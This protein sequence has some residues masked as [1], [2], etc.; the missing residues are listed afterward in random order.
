MN[1]ANYS[2]SPS[3]IAL[4]DNHKLDLIVFEICFKRSLAFYETGHPY[5]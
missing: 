4:S 1:E 2:P 3:L 5:A